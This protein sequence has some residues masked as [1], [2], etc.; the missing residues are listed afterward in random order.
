MHKHF[1]TQVVERI[2]ARFSLRKNMSHIYSEWISQN[3]GGVGSSLQC[4]YFSGTPKFGFLGSSLSKELLYLQRNTRTWNNFKGKGDPLNQQIEGLSKT[5]TI[6][7]QFE[8][9][10]E[11]AMQYLSLRRL[12][13]CR[14]L[15]LGNS[16][17]VGNYH[18]Q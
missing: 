16:T 3:F 6:G 14:T 5:R 12:P 17:Q 13:S 15:V 7:F 18:P 9:L 10:F 1:T 4:T 8:T 11:E 2:F